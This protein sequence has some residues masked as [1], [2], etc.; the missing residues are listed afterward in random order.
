MSLPGDTGPEHEPGL[1]TIRETLWGSTDKLGLTHE[2]KMQGDLLK[3]HL[4][5]C[6]A[7]QAE[8]MQGIRRVGWALLAAAVGGVG[9]LLVLGAKA[10]LT[11]K[12]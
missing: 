11:G 12:S 5:D 2:V 10:W 8:I 3:Q 4:A 6:N 1:K 9:T 7:R